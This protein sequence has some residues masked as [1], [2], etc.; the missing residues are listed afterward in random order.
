MQGSVI[1]DTYEDPLIGQV[2]GEQ[3]EIE[4]EI[5]HGGFGTVYRARQLAVDRDV[6]VKVLELPVGLRREHH[7]MLVAR[8][9]REAKATSALKHPNTVTLI[10]FGQDQTG[11]L[12][13]V[14]ELL[15]GLDLKSLIL[16]E[17][18]FESQRVAHIASQI[19]GSLSDAHARGFVHR[20]LKPANVFVSNFQGAQYFV[21][22]L[23][24]GIT[25]MLDPG[26]D[27]EVTEITMEGMRIGTPRYM[28]PEQ[29]RGEHVGPS[30]DLY[31]LGCIIFEMLTGRKIYEGPGTVQN[32]I[33]HISAP[34]PKV[35]LASLTR[36][37][38]EH[39]NAL[40]ARL[41]SR[42]SETRLQTA[43][44][45]AALL[46]PLLQGDPGPLPDIATLSLMAEDIIEASPSLPSS[47][48]PTPKPSSTSS[49]G[50]VDTTDIAPAPGDSGREW[51]SPGILIAL[52]AIA[53]LLA[54]ILFSG[55]DPA[56]PQGEPAISSVADP[57]GA[58]SIGTHHASLAASLERL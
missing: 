55:G 10:D 58:P 44:E 42:R 4:Y 31:A 19:C 21:K 25:R 57:Q 56:A 27:D 23:D 11:V 15:E 53:L 45:A 33:A 14:L 37:E 39:W 16:G 41:L 35:E 18:P 1:E 48:P 50:G 40:L 8:F 43:D 22:V 28:A 6:A 54:A 17:S 49:S 36:D 34:P 32:A 5:G 13:L 12:F 20:D 26:D 2:L 24:F 3:Y 38:T 52:V 47:P 30:T 51:T 9:R 7:A 46:K 29:L